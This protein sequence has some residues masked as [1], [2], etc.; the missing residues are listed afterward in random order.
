MGFKFTYI[1]SQLTV[2]TVYMIEQ[3]NVWGLL[4]KTSS[5][6]IF[7]YFN[8]A[9]ADITVGTLQVHTHLLS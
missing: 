4:G 9:G 5:I 2:L 6:Y 1:N 7:I 8:S 3:T